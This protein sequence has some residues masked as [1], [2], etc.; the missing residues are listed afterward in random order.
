MIVHSS[1]KNCNEILVMNR[2]Q[3]DQEKI[4]LDILVDKHQNKKSFAN[5]A[6]VRKEL[7]YNLIE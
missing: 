2:D 7:C 3:D 1:S 6:N 4:K 5:H